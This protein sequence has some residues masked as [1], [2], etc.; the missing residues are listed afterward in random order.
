M[1][2][3][4]MIY[5]NFLFLMILSVLVLAPVVSAQV[6][7]ADATNPAAATLEEAP[8]TAEIVD[9]LAKD[10]DG[11]VTLDFKEADINTVLRVMS[12]KSGMNI[13]SGPE[14]QGTV[15][16]RLEDVPWQRAL[17]VVLRTYGYVYE[18]DENIIRVTTRENLALEPVVTKT[19]VLNYSKAPEI[20]EAVRDMLT[21]RGRIKIAER[22]NML[23]ITDIPTNVYTIAEVVEKLDSVTPQAYIDSKVIK[24]DVGASENLG[25]AWNPATTVTG[26]SRP[27]T[28]PFALSE[29]GSEHA[30][31]FL[32]QFYPVQQGI[33][34][35]A[36][37]TDPTFFANPVPTATTTY[38]YGSLDFSAFSAILQMLK[39]RSNTR[40]VSNPRIVVLNNQSANIQV[41]N[42][43]PLP[44][45]ERNETTGS[46]EISGFTFREVGVVLN[47]TPHINSANEILVDL[48]PEI[49]SRGDSITF[50]TFSIPSFNVTK[51]VTQVLIR[52]GETIA[53]GGLMTDATTTNESRVPFLSDIP[54]VGKV[55]RSKRQ[56]AGDGNKKVETLFFVTVT[57]VDT[58]GQPADL[59][60]KEF[61]TV[62]ASGDADAQTSDEDTSQSK[63]MEKQNDASSAN[64]SV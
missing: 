30:S 18:R 7:S 14:V 36:N 34:V 35:A 8:G 9:P 40:V 38:T 1:T 49:S 51:A 4:T 12:L 42:D 21:E 37:A 11:K 33:T 50:G 25:I 6:M 53:I 28:F 32:T 26:S 43:V 2:Y 45:F 48:Q 58:E 20:Q 59:H 61:E 29:N 23:V 64:A 10:E 5:R 31:R 52:S 57:M 63:E 54:L 56:T 15:T 22:M 19:F 13:V 47:V 44:T 27:T 55:F 3:K 60:K 24:T 62:D 46:V 41:G 17:D 39:S 16:I